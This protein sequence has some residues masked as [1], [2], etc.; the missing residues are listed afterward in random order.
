M[1]MGRPTIYSPELAE[2]ICKVVATNP[3]GLPTLCKMFDFM[4]SAETI[5]V[6]RWKRPDFAVKY[7]LAKQFQAE[8]MAESTEDVILGLGQYKF[9]DKDGATRLDSGLVAEARLL[10]DTRKWHA[11]K[12]AH[13]IY[14]DRTSIDS[15]HSTIEDSAERLKKQKEQEKDF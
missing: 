10:V 6:W 14:G 7:A 2:E 4:P 9:K 12:L 11:S 13:K 5:N 15:T 8:L 3:I 1:V